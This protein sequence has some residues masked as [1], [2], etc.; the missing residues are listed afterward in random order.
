MF[1]VDDTAC[2]GDR[3]FNVFRYAFEGE[4]G[5][6]S[7]SDADRRCWVGLV[8]VPGLVHGDSIVRV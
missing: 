1:V 6:S 8:T 5:A 3:P 2:L 4:R 7:G